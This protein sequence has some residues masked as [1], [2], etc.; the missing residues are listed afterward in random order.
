M[1]NVG[2]ICFGGC[3]LI[4]AF[5]EF[6]RLRYF[7][8]WSVRVEWAALWSGV[9]AHTAFL[10]Y[11]TCEYERLPLSS[12]RDWV[13]VIAWVLVCLTLFL[14]SAYKEK[15]FGM[16]FLPGILFLLA[17]AKWVADDQVFAYKPASEAWGAVHGGAMMM[18]TVS[19]LAG[20]LSGIMYL[21]QA[22]LL[23]HPRFTRFINHLPSLEWLHSANCGAM[24]FS[25][26]F[27]AGGILSG[28]VLN[29]I[30]KTQGM[31]SVG[32]SDPFILGAT[33][34][35][36][37]YLGSYAISFFWKF[38]QEGHLVAY[39]TI[40]SFAA[41][42]LILTFGFFTMHRHNQGVPPKRVETEN[43]SGR[44]SEEPFKMPLLKS[45]SL[46]I[47]SENTGISKNSVISGNAGVSKDAEVSK[48]VEVSENAEVS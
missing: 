26:F 16:F 21:W 44:P 15:S 17:G 47:I 31:P 7:S 37:W 28:L 25:T 5:M 12:Q 36:V 39:R 45:E 41:L 19:V 34:L 33:L 11:R 24:K 2:I 40:L 43:F 23:K 3:Y 46:V 14:K 18:V 1:Q 22:W 20:F 10:Y 9:F 32:M 4:A 8:K 13:I 6:L 27:L 29:E 48:S 35:L 30:A 38:S 42:L